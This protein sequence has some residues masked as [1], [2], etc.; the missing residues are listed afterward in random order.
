MEGDFSYKP[1]ITVRRSN[2]EEI[3]NAEVMDP[4]ISS[5]MW[6]K[7]V[8]LV[9]EY[10]PT[11]FVSVKQVTDMIEQR[12]TDLEVK[13]LQRDNYL[14]FGNVS[15]SQ[16]TAIDQ[17]REKF[18]AHFRITYFP[19]ISTLI[20]KIPTGEH[21]VSHTSLYTAIALKLHDMGTDRAE[22]IPGGATTVIS[23]RI[24]G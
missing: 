1:R 13:R 8:A 15:E 6:S 20:I 16:F 12:Q 14:S 5:K 7:Q 22:F 3:V 18:G 23:E 21:E 19:D 24:R 9:R 4:S 17:F 10:P 2:T 11:P